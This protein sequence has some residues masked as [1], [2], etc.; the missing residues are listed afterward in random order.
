MILQAETENFAHL[1][2]Y[3]TR[4]TF[5]IR[6][7]SV[8]SSIDEST[9]SRHTHAARV[10]AHEHMLVSI[11]AHDNDAVVAQLLDIEVVAA[12]ATTQRGNQRA[13][14]GRRQHLVEARPLDIEDLALQRQDRLR[15]PI[16]PLLG[17]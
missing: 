16:A 8:E 14:F 9:N 1:L 13:D 5:L 12:D 7:D 15:A 3:A 17:G 11:D 10:I 4:D 6:F 2:S